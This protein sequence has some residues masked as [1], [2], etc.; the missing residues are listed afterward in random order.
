MLG[1]PNLMRAY[2]AGNV[3]LA[4]AV[5]TGIADDKAVY[6]YMPDIVRFFTGEEALLKNVP[7]WR[8]RE[9]SPTSKLPCREIPAEANL[10]CW[11]TP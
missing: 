9:M 10:R 4:N 5:G 3:T 11:S 8:C 1:V 6:T 2:R 7:T